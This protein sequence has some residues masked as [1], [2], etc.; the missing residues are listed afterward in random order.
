MKGDKKMRYKIVIVT[1]FII[2]LNLS[3]Q[4]CFA[5][6]SYKFQDIDDTQFIVHVDKNTYTIGSFCNL[7]EIE[8]NKPRLPPFVKRI[9][10]VNGV[11]CIDIF[12]Y[13][14]WIEIGEIFDREKVKSKIRKILNGYGAKEEF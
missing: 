10:V 1:F 11:D 12:N 6:T 14:I 3:M 2:V 7:K 5:L 8:R 13:E 4:K 9:F